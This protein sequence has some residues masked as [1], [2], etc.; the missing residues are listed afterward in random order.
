MTDFQD[1]VI[2][3]TNTSTSTTSNITNDTYRCQKKLEV[4]QHVAHELQVIAPIDDIT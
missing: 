3:T 2:S 4:I 1:H